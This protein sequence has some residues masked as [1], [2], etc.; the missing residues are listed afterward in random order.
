MKSG[1][2]F[3]V[4]RGNPV[5]AGM[6]AAQAMELAHFSFP[7]LLLHQTVGIQGIYFSRLQRG[8]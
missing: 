3:I 5:R 1:T 2:L 7:L 6:K 4:N 8:K